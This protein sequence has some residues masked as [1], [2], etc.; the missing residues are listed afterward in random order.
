MTKQTWLKVG[1]VWKEAKS[2]WNKI[3]G[4][5]KKDVMPKGVISGGYKE[6]MS[7]YNPYIYAISTLSPS[8]LK[9]YDLNGSLVQSVNVG[10]AIRDIKCDVNGDVYVLCD[11][12]YLYRYDINLIPISSVSIGTGSR[13]LCLSHSK[14]A[15][16]IYSSIPTSRRILF[17]SKSDLSNGVSVWLQSTVVDM[18]FDNDELLYVTAGQDSSTENKR[19]TKMNAEGVVWDKILTKTSTVSMGKIETYGSYIFSTYDSTLQRRLKTVGDTTGSNVG[20]GQPYSVDKYG[21]MI[22]I[23]ANKVQSATMDGILTP[24][25]AAE[26]YVKNILSTYVDDSLYVSAGLTQYY[27]RKTSRGGAA[28]W[29]ISLGNYTNELA[30]QGDLFDLMP[31]RRDAFPAKWSELLGG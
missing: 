29:S 17:L 27:L 15:V 16:E 20:A 18:S 21:R 9:K 2:A 23:V 6:F 14:V 31:G 25:F 1:D 22:V 13:S 19:V 5:W 8:V 3:D 24:L 26:S 12:N 4:V 7:Y 10:S 11:N 28:I 30:N